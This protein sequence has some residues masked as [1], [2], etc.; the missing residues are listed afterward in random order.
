[1]NQGCKGWLSQ[2]IVVSLFISIKR[3][4]EYTVG[5]WTVAGALDV[6]TT[7]FYGAVDPATSTVYIT[8]GLV[9]DTQA[10]NLVESI[11]FDINDD[12]LTML[13]ERD[14]L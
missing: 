11:T 9:S 3:A 2:I 8:G 10:K 1:M 5:N 12:A 6:A 14:S 13:R 4:Q 7:Q